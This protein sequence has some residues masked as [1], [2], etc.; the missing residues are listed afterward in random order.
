MTNKK[1][2]IKNS[3]HVNHQHCRAIKRENWCNQRR[4]M[5]PLFFFVSVWK[6]CL[7]PKST[8]TNCVDRINNKL[9]SQVDESLGNRRGKVTKWPCPFI[10]PDRTSTTCLQEWNE[11]PLGCCSRLVE[12]RDVD[13]WILTD[14]LLRLGSQFTSS[15]PSGQEQQSEEY[16][17]LWIRCCQQATT[18]VVLDAGSSNT[19]VVDVHSRL[20]GHRSFHC[21]CHFCVDCHLEEGRQRRSL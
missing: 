5:D 17:R 4:I 1:I 12:S 8:S 6:N 15:W 14:R 16:S 19:S 10:R 11:R 20:L 21:V 9:I 3:F 18:T 2:I 7:L 13:L